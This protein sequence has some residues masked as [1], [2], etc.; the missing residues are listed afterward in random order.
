MKGDTPMRQNINGNWEKIKKDFSGCRQTTMGVVQIASVDQNGVPNMTPIGSLFL[1]GECQ[2]FFCN[3]FPENLN[4]NIESNDRVCIIAMNTSKW[5]WL[6]SLFNGRFST[7][8]GIKLF[9]RI[10]RRRP[11]LEHEKTRW[12]K[13]IRPFRFLKG[14]DRLWKNM[15]YVSDIRFDAYE[16]LKAGEMTSGF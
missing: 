2:G 10:S 4:K 5:F 16:Y 7:C 15:Q 6:K 9:G 8:P 3:R 11:I 12:E 14:Y 13:Q 1:T